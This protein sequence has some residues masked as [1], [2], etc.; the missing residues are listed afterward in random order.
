MTARY[1]VGFFALTFCEEVEFCYEQ[2]LISRLQTLS[3]LKSLLEQ[4]V[5]IVSHNTYLVCQVKKAFVCIPRKFHIALPAIEQIL[6]RQRHAADHTSNHVTSY[7]AAMRC[8][9]GKVN[10]D[11]L[12]CTRRVLV[13]CSIPF[14]IQASNSGKSYGEW[15]ILFS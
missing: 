3:R 4:N 2:S 14:T 10:Q 13:H 1:T 8:A 5:W 11:P 7:H 6:K 9:R 15:K 12:Q